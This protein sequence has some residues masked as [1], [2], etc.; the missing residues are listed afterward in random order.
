GELVARRPDLEGVG[1]GQHRGD[2]VLRAVV[3]ELV[4]P[5]VGPRRQQLGEDAVRERLD[6][7]DAF[8]WRW[9]FLAGLSGRTGMRCGGGSPEL[10]RDGTDCAIDWRTADGRTSG[11]PE[12]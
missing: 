11:P 5:E 8:E 12:A 4:Q 1:G 9:H 7:E 3:L 2:C 6:V 10:C